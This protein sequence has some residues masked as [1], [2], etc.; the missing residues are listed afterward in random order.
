VPFHSLTVESAIEQLSPH[1]QRGLTGPE[2]K[3]R[4][5]KYGAGECHDGSRVVY[6]PFL[7]VFSGAVPVALE[8]WWVMTP[9]SLLSSVAVEIKL[10]F[11][12]RLTAGQ[13]Q[14]YNQ[15]R[16]PVMFPISA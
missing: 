15:A 3:A 9:F 4:L 5:E 1:L 14:M 10:D 11:C 13:P 2:V 8:G 7:Q 16:L 12:D 6:A